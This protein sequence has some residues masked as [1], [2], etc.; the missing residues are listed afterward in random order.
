MSEDGLFHVIPDNYVVLRARGVYKQAKLYARNAQV[1]AEY[2]GGFV[3]LM[4]RRG[5]TVPTVSWEPTP[6]MFSVR[7]TEWEAPA[8]KLIAAE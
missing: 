2:G 1:Y 4:G 7:V 5:T 6:L 8:I 3:R